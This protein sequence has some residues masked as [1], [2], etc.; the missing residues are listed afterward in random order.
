[1]IRFTYTGAGWLTPVMNVMAFFV[2]LLVATRFTVS[3]AGV[4]SCVAATYLVTAVVHSRLARA[5]NS[6]AAE[7]GRIWHERHTVN[8]VPM[9]GWDFL[10]VVLALLC[11]PVILGGLVGGVAAIVLALVAY[12]A[13]GAVWLASEALSSAPDLSDRRRLAEAHGWRY[14]LGDPNL[15]GRWPRVDG[16][17]GWR[18][19]GAFAGDLDGVPFVA[20]DAKYGEGVDTSRVRSLRRTTCVVHLPARDQPI[21][22]ASEAGVADQLSSPEVREVTETWGLAGWVVHERDLVLFIDWQPRAPSADEV[23]QRSRGLVE[24]SRILPPDL[25]TSLGP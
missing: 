7:G 18:A 2:G 25:P 14:W 6:H 22:T 4:A 3:V 11:V 24:L 1:V 20:F 13:I 15:A 17:T 21:A 19:L 8:G 5:L 9:E 10:P 16:E 12:L 23:L